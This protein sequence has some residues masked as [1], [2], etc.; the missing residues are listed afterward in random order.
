MDKKDV[1]IVLVSARESMRSM[2]FR[3]GGRLGR[4]IYRVLGTSHNREMNAVFSGAA[5]FYRVD[6]SRGQRFALRRHV[7]M[8]EKGLCMRPRRETFAVDY[9]E[10]TVG[11]LGKCMA[12]SELS[13][14][15]LKWCFDV[16]SAYFDATSTSPNARI[17]T[18]RDEFLDL[19]RPDVPIQE[20]AP[21]KVGTLQ[22]VVSIEALEALAV[23]RTSVR[24]YHSKP[25]DRG[26]IDRA[27]MVALESPSACNRVPWTMRI[28]D[29]P[30]NARLV[31][32]VAMG[33]A[34]YSEQVSNV[35]VLVGNLGA[36]SNERDRHL[37]YID[38]S[39][40]AMSFILALQAQ[41]VS[42][43]CVNWPDIAT[44]E[45]KMASLLGLEPHERVVMLILFGYADEQGLT[46][47][48]GKLPVDA[49]RT[50][51]LPKGRV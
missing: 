14:I 32:G 49:I 23:S 43:C 47:Y 36:Y 40:A 51:G 20:S 4:A 45:K 25:V 2:F 21:Y 50:F 42:S 7:H 41:G 35:A 6:R 12:G 27:L 39:L 19:A 8:L 3:R 15:E 33:T 17:K 9:I 31:A 24:S 30:E 26:V 1:K 29:D 38:G 5:E 16:L 44:R 46:P 13:D 18:A 28:M 22:D 11:D 48:S 34:G 37:I 10:T